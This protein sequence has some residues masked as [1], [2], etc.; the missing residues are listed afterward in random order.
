MVIIVSCYCIYLFNELVGKEIY[1]H[2]ETAD[3][4]SAVSTVEHIYKQ[5]HFFNPRIL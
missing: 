5:A 3:I 4:T 2:R 1:L